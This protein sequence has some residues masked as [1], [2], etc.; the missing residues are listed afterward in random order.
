M[1]D[2]WRNL[3]KSKAEKEQEMLHAYI[4]NALPAHERADVEA[5]LAHDTY[6][7]AEVESLRQVKRMMAAV[8]RRHVPRNFTL[9]PAQY[10]RPARQPLLQAQ[11]VLRLATA[12]TAIIFVVVLALDWTGPGMPQTVVFEADMVSQEEVAVMERSVEVITETITEEVETFAITAEDAEEEI[13]PESAP[14][15]DGEM[16]AVPESEPYPV[17]EDETMPTA[18]PE[19]AAAP[20]GE[21][22]DGEVMNGADDFITTT[23]TTETEVLVTAVPSTDMSPAP[24]PLTS[25]QWVQLGLGA[26]LALLLLLL[27]MA[28]R[29][30]SI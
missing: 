20:P 6:L 29:Q 24:A 27:F 18:P 25:T 11:P 7:Q 28:R 1:F 8:P 16:T 4:D 30:A 2:F 5:R 23:V 21:A 3:T 17:D 14:V 9:D 26:L 15:E 19:P 13:L 12:V 10:G 22:V